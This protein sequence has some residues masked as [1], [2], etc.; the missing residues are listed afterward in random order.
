MVNVADLVTRT[1]SNWPNRIGIVAGTQRMTWAEVDAA[2]NRTAH[3]LDGL[4]VRRGDRV[5]LMCTNRPEFTVTY[6]GILKVGAIVVPLN[7]MLK[8]SEVAYHLQDSGAVLLLAV[9]DTPG[10][11]IGTVAQ[12]GQ[13][14]AKECRQ[15]I[16]L[17][18]PAYRDHLAGRS[19]LYETV[20][21]DDEDT[22]VILYTSGTT[23]QPKGAELRHRN[24]RDNALTGGRL[25]E[26]EADVPDVFFC[27]LPLFHSFGQSGMQNTAVAFGGTMVMTPRFEA[28][29]ALELMAAE[30]VTY[31]GGV[32]TMYWKLLEAGSRRPDLADRLRL[33]V[34]LAGGAPLA[35]EL[36]E[37]FRRRFGITILE[38]YG[39]SETSPL[40]CS[41]RPHERLRVGSIGSAV[42]GVQLKLVD[43]DGQDLQHNA[44]SV[45]EIAVFGHNVMKGY[46]RRPEATASV[47]TD[48][49]L[50]TGD[51]ARRDD[52]GF[53]YIVDRRGDMILRGGFN[54]YPRELEELLMTHPAVSLVAVLGVPHEVL[55]Q[56]IKAVVV[57]AAG[58]QTRPDEIIEWARQRIAAY[59]YPRIVEFREE[60]PLTSTGKILKRAI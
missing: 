12:Q 36:H 14:Q 15:A 16:L 59:K 51:L 1:A 31:F 7:V 46:F 35:V 27:A 19:D 24:I 32:P 37:R 13:D 5:A 54:V 53:Y 40:A 41:A 38:G 26:V 50:R 48:G 9:G 52:D 44:D 11:T 23:G 2:S 33:R 39:L 21:V 4:G 6:F 56:E 42:P 43:T 45:G 18:S 3:V 8:S 29:Q 30:G 58:V 28:E 55:G 34:A 57:P 10:S 47:L 49:W 22:A 17:D 20:E 25:F 60:L